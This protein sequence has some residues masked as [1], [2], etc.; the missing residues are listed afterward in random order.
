M[1]RQSTEVEKNRLESEPSSNGIIEPVRADRFW[2]E[3]EPRDMA[4]AAA[5]AIEKQSEGM[6]SV[7]AI[8][9][10]LREIDQERGGAR[11][12]RRRLA[13]RFTDD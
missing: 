4:D 2:D 13:A 5:N 3:V 6:K 7:S 10:P 11:D 1:A 8:A 9:A 12:R